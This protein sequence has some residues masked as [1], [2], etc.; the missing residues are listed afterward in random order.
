MARGLKKL[1]PPK[2]KARLPGSHDGHLIMSFVRLVA[3]IVIRAQKD[4]EMFVF[5]LAWPERAH[6][7]MAAT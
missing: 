6:L 5:A 4:E 2:E 7:K 3:G 1:A